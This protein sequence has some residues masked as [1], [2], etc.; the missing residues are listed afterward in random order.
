MG[1]N[2]F[3]DFLKEHAPNCYYEISLE[4]FRGLR[5]AMDI[6]NL[7]YAMMGVAIKEIVNKTQLTAGQPD[8]SEIQRLAMDKIV[9][10]LGVYLQNGITPVCVF[11]GKPHELKQSHGRSKRKANSDVIRERLKTAEFKL[12]GVDPLFRNQKLVDEYAKY[13]IQNIEVPFDFMNQLRDL[14]VE[15][16]FPVLS[17]T[18]FGLETRDAEGICATLCLKGNDYCI[19]AVTTDSDFHVYGGNIQITEVYPKYTMVRGVR[20]TAYYAKVRSLEA[21][22]QQSGLSFDR[23]RDLCIL[24][25]TD[26]NPNIPGVGVKRSWDHIARH[27]SIANMVQNN[28]D[29]TILNY[30]AV[31]KI[32]ASTI[33]RVQ[34]QSPDFDVQ[35]FNNYAR[36]VFDIYGLRDHAASMSDSL[37]SFN[38]PNILP[39]ESQKPPP[40]T[41]FLFDST[42]EPTSN[43][44]YL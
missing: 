24:H 35:R 6:N 28:V 19:A 10:R 42:D 23:F 40:G 1:I 4:S 41:S 30:P 39:S 17:A 7:A 44:L 13:Y 43:L 32:F 22:L 14:L 9:A 3:S 8:K 18:D 38:I 2:H 15:V 16:G 21:I 26:F 12:Y 29:V 25:G 34:I 5:I 20:I 37:N 36:S 31:L 33:V 27:G 11:D